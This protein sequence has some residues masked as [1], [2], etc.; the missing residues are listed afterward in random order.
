MLFYLIA[1]EPSGDAIGASLM[2]ALSALTNGAA[3]FVGIGGESMAALGLD[4]RIPIRDLALMGF[5][6][7]VPA[8]RRLLRQVRET[9]ADIERLQ[10]AAV[11]TIDSSGFCFRVGEG[12]RRDGRRHGRRPPPVIHYVA[13]M[14]WALREHRARS[15]ARAADHLLTLFPFEPPYFEKVGLPATYVGHPVT[16]GEAGRGDGKQFRR[17]HGIADDAPVLCVLPGSR[18]GEV[19]RLLPVFG[20]TVGRMRRHFPALHVV[21]PT[22]ENVADRV[23]A[24]TGDWA[25]PVHIVRGPQNKFDA[26]AASHAAL[27]ASGS[28]ALELAMARVPMVVGYRLW[29]PTYWALQ[30]AAK[31]EFANLV[32]LLVG[33]LV[34]PE[35]L[36]GDCVPERLETALLQVLS[37]D[38]VRAAQLAAFDQALGRIGQGGAAPSRRAAETILS[39]IA[40][41]TPSPV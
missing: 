3:Q 29:G 26:F 24:A 36:Q 31:I 23:V 35:L 32:N 1:G 34:V 18:A 15:A 33:R 38:A 9:I 7:L 2:R 12:L 27:A 16:E 11:V 10:P 21:L 4:S 40:A 28:V 14:V 22:V 5:V 41:Q 39:L 13:P 17:A 30:R 19:R 37:D 20:Q 8:A 6:E 25:A